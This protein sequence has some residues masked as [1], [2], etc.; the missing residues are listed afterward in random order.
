MSTR[1]DGIILMVTAILTFIAGVV[2]GVTLTL[3]LYR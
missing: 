1:R 2:L 3:P